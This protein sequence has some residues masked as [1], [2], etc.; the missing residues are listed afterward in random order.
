MANIKHGRHTKKKLAS[1][2]HSAKVGRPVMGELKQL[3]G[4]LV[5]EELM[6]DE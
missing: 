3:E 4:Q 2:R 6:S 5:D 1:Q